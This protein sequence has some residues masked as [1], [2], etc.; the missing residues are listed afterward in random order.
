MT[1]AYPQICHH[2]Q[3]ILVDIPTAEVIILSYPPVIRS[4]RMFMSCTLDSWSP[5][6][7]FLQAP[8]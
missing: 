8:S 7:Q 3:T 1:H 4:E 5:L 2:V 6:M